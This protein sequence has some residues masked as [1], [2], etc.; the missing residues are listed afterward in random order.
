MLEDESSVNKQVIKVFVKLI[1]FF[2]YKEKIS[3]IIILIKNAVVA[4][5]IKIQISIIPVMIIDISQ[6][7]TVFPK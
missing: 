4:G 5:V 6:I 3:S 7:I 1:Y 2:R